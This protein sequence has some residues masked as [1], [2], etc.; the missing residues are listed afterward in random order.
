MMLKGDHPGE[1]CLV[2]SRNQY[3]CCSSVPSRTTMEYR[4]KYEHALHCP[5]PMGCMS[6]CKKWKQFIIHLKNCSVII[7][8]AVE[9]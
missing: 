8:F 7:P 1:G 5:S 4:R 6:T 9:A 3:V 2:C